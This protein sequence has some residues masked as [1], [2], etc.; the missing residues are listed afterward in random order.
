MMSTAQPQPS[1]L[2]SGQ[3]VL[4][5]EDEWFIA[6]DI[7]SA[8]ENL[9]GEVV[10]PVAECDDALALIAESVSIDLAVIDINL[11]GQMCFPVADALA[12]RG[13]PF[14]FAT[15]YEPSAIPERFLSIRRWE[16]PFDQDALARSLVDER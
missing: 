5:I 9:G 15:G 14:V 10:G 4:V 2:L 7:R 12:A 1:K 13:T 8:I 6:E 11:Q 16:K 3:R